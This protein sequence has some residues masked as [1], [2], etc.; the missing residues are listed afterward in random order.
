MYQI[1]SLNLL[2][3]IIKETFKTVIKSEGTNQ[4]YPKHLLAYFVREKPAALQHFLTA[5]LPPFILLVPITAE[6]SWRLVCL[7]ALMEKYLQ[8]REQIWCLGRDRD[9]SLIRRLFPPYRV[10]TDMSQCPL[11]L[12]LNSSVWLGP[13]NPRLLLSLTYCFHCGCC[14][15]FSFEKKKRTEKFTEW[16]N[17]WGAGF[18][19]YSILDIIYLVIMCKR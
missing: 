1:L 4:C 9:A 17:H 10:N 13:L 15:S 18:I 19:F 16:E 3:I 5:S 8:F 7:A 2:F 14:C 12:S 11:S 6:P